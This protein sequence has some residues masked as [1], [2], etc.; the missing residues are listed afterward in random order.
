MFSQI[1]KCGCIEIEHR[2]LI[3]VVEPC[4]KHSTEFDEIELLR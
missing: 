2:G 4:K 3:T 1:L